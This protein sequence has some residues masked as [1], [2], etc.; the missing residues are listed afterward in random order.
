MRKLNTRLVLGN[1]IPFLLLAVAIPV[2]ADEGVSPRW[3]LPAGVT[4]ISRDIYD[5]HM[6]ILGICAVIACVV[7]GVMLY[8]LLKHRRSRGH[9]AADFHESTLVEIAWTLIPFLILVGMAIPATRV[10]KEMHNFEH[11]DMTVQVTGFQWK[12]KYDYLDEGISFFSNLATSSEQIHNEVPKGD[13]YLREVDHPLVLPIHK[14]VLFLFTANDVI[15][16]WWVPEFGLKKDTIPGFI[17]ESWVKIEKPGIYRGQCA[18][19][20]G[21]N[22]GFMPIV[23]EAKTEEDYAAWVAKQKEVKKQAAAA[24]K[25][26]L[27]KAA[28][29]E[30]GEKVYKDTCSACHQIN[31]QGL[32]PAFPSLKDSD[33]VLHDLPGHLHRVIFG[34]P[35]TAM[36]AFGSQLS[37]VDIAAVITY[38]RN[39]FGINTGDVVQALDVVKARQQ[40]H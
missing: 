30:R 20:C 25:L 35:N 24:S 12:W 8:A 31:G 28:L 19:L 6:I 4:S 38:E 26:E 10:L 36:Q 40:N 9:Q 3:N 7:F 1:W 39:A 15:H 2:W 32:P 11:S 23:V 27:S 29:M 17:N 18:E 5:L 22:H 13:H 14:K 21:I 33:I 16:S 37:D 34:V